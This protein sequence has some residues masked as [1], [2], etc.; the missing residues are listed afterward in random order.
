MNISDDQSN[1]PANTSAEQTEFWPGKPDWMQR[2]RGTLRNRLNAIVAST[3]LLS[4][5]PLSPDA[6]DTLNQIVKTAHDLLEVTDRELRHGADKA[7]ARDPRPE[8]VRKRSCDLLYIEDD[9]SSVTLVKRSLELRP[10]LT[11]KHATHGQ[12]GIEMAKSGN[13]RLVLLDLSLP[14]IHGADVLRSLQS[15]PQ[16]QDIPVVVLSADAIATQIERLLASGARNYLTKPFTSDQLLAVV[17]EWTGRATT[18]V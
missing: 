13:P 4:I 2:M 16:T 10:E 5:E 14:D 12:L 18:G 1:N 8:P 9:I 6:R 17:D 7:G 11:L 15:S 3:D